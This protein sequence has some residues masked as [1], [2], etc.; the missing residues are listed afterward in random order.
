MPARSLE[1]RRVDKD[2]VEYAQGGG[3]LRR[4]IL[5]YLHT[6]DMSDEDVEFGRL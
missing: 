6:A 1:K 2:M 4:Y 3:C 5:K